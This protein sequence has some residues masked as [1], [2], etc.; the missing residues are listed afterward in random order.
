MC[1]DFYALNINT[2]LDVIPL[3]HIDYFLY[4]L[5]KAKH[6]SSIDLATDYHWVGIDKGDTYKITFLTNERL[7]EYDLMLFRLYN[8]PKNFQD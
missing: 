1:I 8:V 3:P 7:Y 2:K 4:R 6:L 5:G